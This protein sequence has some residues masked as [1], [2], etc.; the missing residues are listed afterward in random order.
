MP[1]HASRNARATVA[2]IA[3]VLAAVA[4]DTASGQAASSFQDALTRYGLS[5]S[6]VYDGEPAVNLAGGIK[7]GA[8]YV[9]NLFMQLTVDGEKLFASPETTVFLNGIWIQGGQPSHLSGDAQGVSN[10]AAPSAVVLEEAWVQRN[11][12]D[13]R[14]SLLA[15]RYD[16]NSEFYKLTS[17]GL[18][19]NGSFGVGAE[20]AQ[21]GVEGPSIFPYTSIGMRIAAKATPNTVFRLAVLDG[22]PYNRPD[23]SHGAFR[24]GDGA[25]IVAEGAY[26]I[27]PASDDGPADRRFLIGRAADQLPYTDKI[28]VGTWYYTASFNDLSQ[29]DAAGQPVQHR[30]SGGAYVLLDKQLVSSTNGRQHNVSGFLQLGLGDAR[31]DRFGS[32]VG[33]GL[34]GTGYVPG[35]PKD[36]MGISV[37]AARNGSH[38]IAAQNQ[39]GLGVRASEIAVEM[40][41]LTQY[42]AWLAIQP[43]LQY[44]IHPNTDPTLR[45][46]LMFQLR[47][48]VAY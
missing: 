40:T 10:M 46:A 42:N 48:E 38:Y 44:V 14:L 36:E 12:F 32:Y 18:F 4:S 3:V 13:D 17:A 8:T 31:V 11:F 19:L 6:L 43:D 25:L 22:V 21:S 35:R 37:A 28:A 45:S 15:G 27:R 26:L 24:P 41:Y 47:F 2:A 34:V 33:A 16:L 1:S 9:G 23:G 20:F 39:Q 30:G 29:V 7:R 5:P